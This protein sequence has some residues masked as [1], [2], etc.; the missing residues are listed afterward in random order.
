MIFPLPSS[1]QNAPTMTVQGMIF[2]ACKGCQ[3]LFKTVGIRHVNVSRFSN[4]VESCFEQMDIHMMSK[5]LDA[6]IHD[7]RLL[8]LQ[9]GIQQVRNGVNSTQ[10]FLFE[11]L[12]QSQFC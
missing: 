12:L 7:G 10:F 4:G 6:H 8:A 3:E 11:F 1:P 5:S 2:H 9:R